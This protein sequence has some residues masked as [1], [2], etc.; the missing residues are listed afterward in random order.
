MYANVITTEY[1]SPDD[2]EAAVE[3]LRELAPE[4]SQAPGFETVFFVRTGPAKTTHTAVFDTRENAEATRKKM[5]PRFKEV[6]GPHLAG[7]P[8]VEPGEVVLHA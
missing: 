1:G 3:K 2:L 7:E 6:V 5:F 4:V 8:T